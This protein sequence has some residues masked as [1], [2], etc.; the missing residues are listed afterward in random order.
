MIAFGCAITDPEQ[1]SKFA[2]PGIELAAAAE[3]GTK[4]LP[5]Q[6]TSSI[7][8]SYNVLLDDAAKLPDLEAL[9][10]VHQDAEIVDPDFMPKL[11]QALEGPDVGLVGCAGAIG[12]RSLA[13]W[14][15]AVTWASFVHRYAELGGGDLPA[16]SW[17]PEETPSF[18]RTG[19]VDS[20]DGFVMCFSPW[21]VQN[22]RFD[23][24]LG[25]LHGYDFDYCMQ[26]REA[27]KK[28][29]TADFK[30]VHNHSLDLVSNP[31]S[32]VEA[33][34]RLTEKWEGRM[35]NGDPR[36]TDWKRRALRAEANA[37]VARAEAV[38]AGLKSDAKALWYERR[39]DE[40]KE[41]IGWRITE[42]LRRANQIRRK[43][44]GRGSN[45]DQSQSS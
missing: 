21:V 38:A 19:E 37:S 15:G 43:L 17:R 8:R 23:E 11:R 14:E 25:R 42:P 1:Y 7:F 41:S 32:W 45:G 13:W 5:H 39:L 40:M 24:S 34:I 33:H 27:G 36:G 3:P 10:L 26:V 44:L 28:V 9:V 35:L 4:L 30:V 20:I 6:A 12:V 31:D 16:F 22:I 18:A 29:V 2:E